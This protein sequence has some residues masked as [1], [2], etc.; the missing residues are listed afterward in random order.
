[1]FNRKHLMHYLPLYVF[2]SIAFLTFWYF[3]YN[4]LIQFYLVLVASI[5]YF[6]WGLI[7]HWIHKDLTLE[8]AIEYFAYAVFGV[9]VIFSI[10]NLV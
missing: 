5:Y 1:M 7:H 6:C 9:S 3:S 2:F 10:L 4:R 8:V